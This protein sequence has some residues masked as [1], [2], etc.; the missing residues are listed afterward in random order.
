MKTMLRFTL[1]QLEYA[2]AIAEHGSLAGAAQKLGV[3]QP[4]LSAS[5]QKL[6]DQLGL[7]LF[8]RHHADRRRY[9]TGGSSSK[10]F[11]GPGR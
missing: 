3:A 2:L 5:L 9:L 10:R 1:R 6:E 7:Q 4:S 11:G 8:I